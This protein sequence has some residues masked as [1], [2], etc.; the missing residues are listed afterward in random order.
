MHRSAVLHGAAAAELL[1]ERGFDADMISAA[2]LHDTADDTPIGLP[3]IEERF[4]R[5]VAAL[6]RLVDR[7]ADRIAIV[8]A[9]PH[10]AMET[11]GVHLK[12][13]PES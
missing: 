3:R 11:L 13:G 8:P 6:T 7:D 1:S 5:D 12:I 10:R 4:G 9:R 2:R